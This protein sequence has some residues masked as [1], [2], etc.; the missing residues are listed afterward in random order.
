MTHTDAAHRLAGMTITV[1]AALALTA[2]GSG[3]AAARP[4][5][6]GDTGPERGTAA[7]GELRVEDAWV[8]EPAAPDTGAAYLTVFN[9]AAGDDALVAARASVSDDVELYS[10]S[11]MAAV[12]EIP[13]YGGGSTE[14]QSSGFHL[15]LNGIDGPLPAG[16]TVELTL[17][18]ASGTTI[19]VG[20]PVLEP[21]A[22]A[23]ENAE[24]EHTGH[25]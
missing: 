12:E 7:A 2:C 18:F 19:E 8:P 15:M 20:A 13:V 22:G 14:L 17:T 5:A 3:D 23:E 24:E 10:T 25:H 9:D 16:A 1:A 21:A 6:E 11:R 4:P